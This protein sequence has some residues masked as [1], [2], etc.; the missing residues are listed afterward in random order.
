MGSFQFVLLRGALDVILRV[1]FVV[2]PRHFVGYSSFAVVVDV[3]Q[4]KNGGLRHTKASTPLRYEDQSGGWQGRCAPT[5][6]CTIGVYS[7]PLIDLWCPTSCAHVDY[8]TFRHCFASRARTPTVAL[9]NV[10]NSGSRARALCD[11][12]DGQDVLDEQDDCSGSSP[13]AGR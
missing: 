3:R 6:L 11:L 7:E 4:M 13:T 9:F 5:T 8:F 10:F 12:D 1:K 2:V